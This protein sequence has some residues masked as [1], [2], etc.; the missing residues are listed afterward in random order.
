M[1]ESYLRVFQAA[2][3]PQSLLRR[4]MSGT[5]GLS[6]ACG[7]IYSGMEKKSGPRK[8]SLTAVGWGSACSWSCSLT[9]WGGT[10]LM[11]RRGTPTMTFFFCTT[12]AL[13]IL[14]S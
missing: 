12:A 1:A 5:A 13:G 2:P 7:W 11:E 4:E 6:L 9:S 8:Q 14:M 10:A 3:E